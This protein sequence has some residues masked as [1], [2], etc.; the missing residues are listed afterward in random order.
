MIMMNVG[1]VKKE[2]KRENVLT[3]STMSF[4][5]TIPARRSRRE[6]LAMEK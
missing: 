5:C 2:G 3:E 4:A 1:I 6:V